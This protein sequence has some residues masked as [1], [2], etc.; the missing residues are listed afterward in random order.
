MAGLRMRIYWLVTYLFDFTL[1][2]VIVFVAIAFAY[3]LKFRFFT[4]TPFSV[5]FVLFV[6]FGMTQISFS[7]FI[8]VFFSSVYTST[9]VSFI[10]IIFTALSSNLLNNAFI[11]NPNTSLAAFVITALV[12][13]VA[14]HRAISYISL[15]YL[16]NSPGLSWEKIFQHHQMPTLYGLLFGEFLLFTMLHQYLE[17]VVPSAYGIRYHPLF[18]LQRSFWRNRRNA[19]TTNL[20]SNPNDD[21][22]EKDSKDTESEVEDVTIQITPPDVEEEQK[23]CFSESCKSTIRLLSLT[24]T[25]RILNKKTKV[26]DNL[27]LSVDK[28]QCFGI[29]GPNGAGKTTTLSILSGLYSTSGG[30]A[31]IDGYDITKNLSMVQQSLGVCP[32]DDVL[33]GEMSGRDHLLFYGRMKNLDG[34]ELDLIVDKSLA[35]VMLTDAQDKPVNEYSGGMKRRLSLAISL[36]GY[37]S[38]IVLDEP[39]TGVD[40]FSRRIVW[41]VIKSYK[42]RCAILL[43][44]HNM[45]E[46]EI[47]CD[48]VCIIN[49]GAMKC[50]GR[51]PELKTRYG[52]GYTL[53]VTTTHDTPIH[54]FIC[55]IIPNVK[56]IHEISLNK[57]YSVPRSSVRLSTIF[58][59]IQENKEKYLIS[60]WGLCLSGLDSVLIQTTNGVH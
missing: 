25:F 8:S 58:K 24:K 13:H 1:Y 50:I 29:L 38:A 2:M 55:E 44:T 26:V 57:T 19:A 21:G 31:F 11:L 28:G 5:Y 7:F 40:P 45:E 20:N 34:K 46:A 37:P 49:K 14:F 43:I 6:L 9:V 27:S 18:F 60:D 48:R 32:Q 51:I 56:L 39:T 10:Y 42:N 16:G 17:M 23:A 22:G 4:Q 47:L 12:P 35:E 36:I 3:I 59:S 33:W 53:S 15:A 54:D 41:D 30:T 52:A